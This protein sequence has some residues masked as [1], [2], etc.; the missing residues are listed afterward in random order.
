MKYLNTI[1]TILI[2]L[3]VNLSAQNSY[4]ALTKGGWTGSLAGSMGWDNFK[5]DR[6]GTINKIDG[7]NFIFSS[8]NGRIVEQ[9]AAFGFD[10][11]WRQNSVTT[12]P[13]PNPTNRT[14]FT[15]E[16]VWFLGL[17]AR[18]YFVTG[19]FAFF[20][21][22]SAGYASYNSAEE[23]EDDAALTQFKSEGSASG[24]A[25]NLG[26]GVAHF[27]SPNISFDLTARWE[28]GSLNGDVEDA[29]GNKTDLKVTLGNIYLL[30]GFQIYLK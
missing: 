9:N 26:F 21:E 23:F 30:L 20:P 13:D 4:K 28:G 12:K 8:R 16:R 18:Y 5:T 14:E 19:N 27:V 11:Q 7:F 24:F 17:W 15:R 22:G 25:Y 6:E 29:N 10:F 1:V 2:I 3:T